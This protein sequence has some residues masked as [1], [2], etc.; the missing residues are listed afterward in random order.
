MP[1][2]L[3]LNDPLLLNEWFAV[4]WTSSLLRTDQIAI[5]YRRW[6]KQLSLQYGTP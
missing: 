6:L 3:G 5:A 4:A 1:P 2:D